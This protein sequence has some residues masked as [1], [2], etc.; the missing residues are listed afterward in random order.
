MHGLMNNR[1]MAVLLGTVSA[2]MGAE[3]GL[4][5]E[6]ATGS[7]STEVRYV[8]LREGGGKLLNFPDVQSS[9]WRVLSGG[10]VLRV[11]GEQ[12]LNLP[13]GEE[14]SFLETEAPGG[15][16]VWVFGQYLATT[17]SEG[18]LRTTTNVRMR[19][20]P[21]SDTSSMAHPMTLPRGERVRF[22]ERND[23]SRPLSEDWVK[24]WSPESARA[25]ILES[26]TERVDVGAGAA[27]WKQASAL[28]RGPAERPAGT[29]AEAG[30]RP[31]DPGTDGG[32]SEVGGASVA[33]APAGSVQEALDHAD[34]L[35][36]LAKATDGADFR[37]A[38]AAYQQAVDMAGADS[39]LGRVA[40]Q[41]L[42]IARAGADLAALRAEIAEVDATRTQRQKE[43]EREE[44]LAEARN[45]P[46]WGRFMARGWV[47]S[48]EVE[49]EMRFF[50]DWRGTE[51]CE[52]ICSNGRYDM[53]L[54]RGYEVGVM[55]TTSRGA[56]AAPALPA[57]QP[58][59]LDPYRVEVIS[60]SGARDDK[61]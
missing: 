1:W 15:L 7:T 21:T 56:I 6:G 48:R 4:A 59:R 33:P 9:V 47:T 34:E 53:S 38:V 35:F 19:P 61:R 52:A 26:K 30:A 16:P 17:E 23:E 54:F 22:I 32:A 2:L 55:G 44:R 37:E 5:Q 27:S 11:V 42:Q 50:I 12:K 45:D 36:E 28:L 49:G 39:T 18:V 57:P 40:S 24:V 10:D 58:P 46:L 29:V 60:G 41:R 51:V 43:L 31:E 20:K 14:L 13:S 8:R 25:W 3:V